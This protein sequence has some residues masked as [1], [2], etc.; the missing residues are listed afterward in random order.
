MYPQFLP[1]LKKSRKNCKSKTFYVC[2]LLLKDDGK[3]PFE[4]LKVLL[5]SLAV[6]KLCHFCSLTCLAYSGITFN[7]LT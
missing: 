6:L 1:K 7:C 4:F 3:H 5:F 2:P